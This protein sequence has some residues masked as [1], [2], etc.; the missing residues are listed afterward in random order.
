MAISFPHVRGTTVRA[1]PASDALLNEVITGISKLRAGGSA[2][3]LLRLMLLRRLGSSL[4]AFRAALLRHDAYLDLSARAASAGRSL[5]PREF[6][7]CFPRAAES[8]VQL[9]LLPLLLELPTS[10]HQLFAEDRRVVAGLFR[11]LF[12]AAPPDPK[13]DALERLL[14]ARPRKTIVFTDAQPTVR[15]LLRRLR[16]RRVAPG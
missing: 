11:L 2:A 13:L 12:R 7:R 10:G 5:N 15:Y 8:D 14:A 1:G 3:P 16:H 6:Q 9:V 4:P